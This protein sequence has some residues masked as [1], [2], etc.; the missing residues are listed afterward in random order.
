VHLLLGVLLLRDAPVTSLAVGGAETATLTSSDTDACY[1]DDE[2]A[3]N[4]QAKA[5]SPATRPSPRAAV[6]AILW[7][8]RRG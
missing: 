6:R 1:V 7:S 3:F 2:P 8:T 5:R 4:A